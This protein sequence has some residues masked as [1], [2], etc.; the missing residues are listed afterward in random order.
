MIDLIVTFSPYQYLTIILYIR[1]QNYK[2]LNAWSLGRVMNLQME[3]VALLGVGYL[4]GYRI[5]KEKA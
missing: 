4:I 1:I 2:C 3:V 5:G